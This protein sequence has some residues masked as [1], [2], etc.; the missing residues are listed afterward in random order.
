MQDFVVD[1]AVW[2]GKFLGI[3]LALLLGLRLISIR[4]RVKSR[5]SVEQDN[6]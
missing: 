3:S 1:F 2:L 6:S 5:K 4:L